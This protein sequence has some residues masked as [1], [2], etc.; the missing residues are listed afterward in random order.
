VGE[1]VGVGVG[2][3]DPCGFPASA[4]GETAEQAIARAMRIKAEAELRNG[5]PS[6]SVRGRLIEVWIS[7]FISVIAFRLVL[8]VGFAIRYLFPEIRDGVPENFSERL[9]FLR[10][11]LHEWSRIS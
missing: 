6:R 9:K 2:V 4:A 8:V 3:G 10:H 11:E 1:G 7:V 5:F